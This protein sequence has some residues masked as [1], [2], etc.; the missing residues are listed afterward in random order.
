M[1]VEV[2]PNN[3]NERIW[4]SQNTPWWSFASPKAKVRKAHQVIVSIKARDTRDD[5]Y[6]REAQEEATTLAP[7]PMTSTL[8]RIPQS[9]APQMSI[10]D[11]RLSGPNTMAGRLQR[12][13]Y[14][15][16]MEHEANG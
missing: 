11:S 9:E 14:D 12:A 13:A 2:N 10:D 1:I 15:L 5:L 6:M 8:P 4:S 7:K 3:S 16:L